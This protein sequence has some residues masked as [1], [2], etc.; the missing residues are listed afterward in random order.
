MRRLIGLAILIVSIAFFWPADPARCETAPLVLAPAKQKITAEFD[1][2]DTAL[3]LAARSLAATGLTGDKAR[4]ALDKLCSDFDYAVDCAAVD[5]QGKMV[6]I[7]PAPFRKFEGTDISGQKQVKLLRKTGKPVLSDV[8]RAAE[9]F[10]AAD[11]EYPVVTPAGSKLGSVSILFHPEKL[12]GKIIVPLV[13]GMSVNIWVMEKGGLIL[14]DVDT[15]QIGLN[16]FT[17]KLYQP[18]TSLIRLGRRIAA[19][20]EGKG[21]YKFQSSAAKK[22]VEKSAFWQSVS[23]YGTEWRIV[24]IHV[25]H[26]SPT[27]ET[28]I[29][30]P[31]ETMEG[32]LESLAASKPLV[33]AL[34][35]EDSAEVMMLFLEF[36]KNV[37][38]IYS[39]QWIDEKGI[40]RFGYPR[41]NS[42]TDYDYNAN[43][44]RYDQ[45]FLKII[46]E[47]KPARLEI[48]LIEGR[49]GIFIFRPL[50][51]G[52]RYL[53]M[54]YFIRLKN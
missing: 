12:L 33:Q 32:Q 38:G 1:R 30:V 48:P 9:G 18:H 40:N 49:T 15:P 24:S 50:F 46:A 16:L 43:H 31:A 42:L 7:E 21:A 39:V 8:F 26:K 5:S 51:D 2:L 10:Q 11:A 22:V 28:G 23:L 35:A 6:T 13:R 3:A 19:K 4:A 52:S 45:D 53:G 20:P 27:A 34:A 14:Y 47:R 36:Y 44:V 54:I 37:P 41:E 17:A 29:A 25:E